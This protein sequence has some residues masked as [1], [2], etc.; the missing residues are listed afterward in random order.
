MNFHIGEAV[1]VFLCS[2]LFTISESASEI[3]HVKRVFCLNRQ[4]AQ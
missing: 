1:S 3:A 2:A 4:V